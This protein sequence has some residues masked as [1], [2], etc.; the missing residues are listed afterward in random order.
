MKSWRTISKPG[1][2]Q[3]YY[4]KPMILYFPTHRKIVKRYLIPISS[5]DFVNFMQRDKFVV[6]ALE[7]IYFL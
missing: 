7:A 6:A 1:P 3:Q 2:I 4:S 5:H